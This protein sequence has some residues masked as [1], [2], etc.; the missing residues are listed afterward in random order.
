[1][2]IRILAISDFDWESN[3]RRRLELAGHADDELRVMPS[4]SEALAAA[5]RDRPDLIIHDLYCLDMDGCEFTRKLKWL[6]SLKTVPILLVGWLSPAILYPRARQAGADGYLNAAV[7]SQ[8]LI[9]ARSALLR[10]S[11]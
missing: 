9:N 4:G 3:L 8:G 1:M 2:S 11:S 10:A 6:P 7:Y 5:E